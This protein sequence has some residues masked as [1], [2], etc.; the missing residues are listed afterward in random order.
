[1]RISQVRIPVANR[2]WQRFLANPYVQHAELASCFEG[3]PRFLY[4]L[5]PEAAD[6]LATLL[7]QSNTEPRWIASDLLG[8]LSPQM[9]ASK[10]FALGLTT[11]TVLRF[12]VRANP[13]VKRDGKRR[14]VIGETSLVEWLERKLGAIG[15]RLCGAV[16]IPEGPLRA[17]RSEPHGRRSM[18]FSSV[19]FEGEVEVVD[20]E[21]FRLGVEAG[22]GSAKAFGFGLVSL[23]RR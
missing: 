10:E 8:Q 6:G 16:V 15:A 5:E 23:A 18:T 19:R 9:R 21:M 2:K 12:R 7:V 14:A 1:M 11:G 13:T 17:A 22:I 4:R 3:D 20:P